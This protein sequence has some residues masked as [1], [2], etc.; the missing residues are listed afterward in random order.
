MDK[1]HQ[2][3]TTNEHSGQGGAAANGKD[4]LRRQDKVEEVA[5]LG[6]HTMGD[7][8]GE[9]GWGSKLTTSIVFYAANKKLLQ[10]NETHELPTRTPCYHSWHDIITLSC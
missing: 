3:D 9:T 7:H 6:C 1:R 5:L 2:M 4:D 8:C 10:F